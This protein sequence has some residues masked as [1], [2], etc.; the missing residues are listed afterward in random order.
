MPVKARRQAFNKADCAVPDQ[1]FSRGR[2]RDAENGL[3]PTVRLKPASSLLLIRPI[4]QIDVLRI[5]TAWNGMGR[6]GTHPSSGWKNAG[7][8]RNEGTAWKP[9]FQRLETVRSSFLRP[10]AHPWSS[11]HLGIAIAV[12]I[13]NP[14]AKLRG[15]SAGGDRRSRTIGWAGR[16]SRRALSGLSLQPPSLFRLY[17]AIGSLPQSRSHPASACSHH[18]SDGHLLTKREQM[19]GPMTLSSVHRERPFPVQLSHAA[20]APTRFRRLRYQT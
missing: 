15:L 7:T 14:N 5:S 18:D 2:G 12:A 9:S 10:R 6:G 20:A 11:F 17:S 13:G 8:R 3:P 1:G 4:G 19:G 16:L